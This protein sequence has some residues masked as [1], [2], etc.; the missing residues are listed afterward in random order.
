MF[1]LAPKTRS[2]LEFFLDAPYGAEFTYEEIQEATECDAQDEDRQRVY[3][4]NRILERDHRRTLLNMRGRGYKVALPREHVE[5]MGVRK[6]RAGTQIE[7]AQRTSAATNISLLNDSEVQTWSDMTAWVSRV[8]Q[9]LQHH[10]R[11]IA[12]IEKHLGIESPQTVDGIAE[13]DQGQ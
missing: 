5:S 3:S 8:A 13:E 11:R 1:Q 6:R 9:A 4:V 10:D 7:L 2:L 12:N